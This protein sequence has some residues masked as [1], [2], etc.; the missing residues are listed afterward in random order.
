MGIRHEFSGS[1]KHVTFAGFYLSG[2]LMLVPTIAMGITLPLA[3]KIYITSIDYAGHRIGRL[4]AINT[5]GGVLGSLITGF[6]LIP[7]VGVIRAGLILASLYIAAGIIVLYFSKLTRRFKTIYISAG[8]VLIA[9][10]GIM[11]AQADWPSRLQVTLAPGLTTIDYT[12]GASSTVT[13]V[14]SKTGTR[15]AFV[16]GNI[17]VGATPGAKQTVR[18]LAHLPVLLQPNAD[19]ALVI[20]FGMGI[21]TYSVSLHNLEK[22]EVVEI[23][24]EILD[25]A[26]LFVAD[27]HDVINNER[28]NV[29]V[30]DGRNYLLRT[31]HQYS[32]ITADPTHPILGSGN[33][34][35]REYYQQ[36][37]E[38]LQDD[39]IIV[40]YVPLH[41][42]NNS[43]F[44]TLIRTFVSVFPHSSLWFSTSDLVIMGTKKPQLVNYAELDRAISRSPIRQDLELSNI[45]TAPS[46]LGHLLMGENELQEYASGADINTDDHPII[47]FR[48]PTSIGHNTR[49]INLESILP[50]L[51]ETVSYV[52]LTSMPEEN[53]EAI[54]QNL[55]QNDRIRL[56][57]LR[58]LRHDAAN[59]H[60]EAIKEYRHALRLDSSNPDARRLIKDA[61]NRL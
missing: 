36:A 1:L 9:V 20:G 46:L 41:L 6:V 30:E 26:H 27:N 42:L 25:N 59:T 61:K 55:E 4:Y 28:L 34:Y 18:L 47:E 3:N 16:N 33:L 52:D 45:G 7:S 53:R 38:K 51:S 39:G 17:V 8:T 57:I 37:F 23:A 31:R 44:R 29:I 15:A 5:V 24:P 56:H 40:Q 19:S 11:T 58:G 35:T 10:S 60:R 14:E 22:T 50:Y 12:E 43:E 21:T 13:V 49:S 48:G 54:V 32:V 2:F